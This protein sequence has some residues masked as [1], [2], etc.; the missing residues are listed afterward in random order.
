MN[1]IIERVKTNF[2]KN[3]IIIFV[4]FLVWVVALA[5]TVYAYRDSLGKESVGNLEYNYVEVLSS[6]K[7][8]KQIVDTVD[9]VNSV[10][11]RF[12]VYKKKSSNVTIEVIGQDSKKVYGSKTLKVRDVLGA[13]YN[14]VGLTENLDKKTD[15]KI[16][17]SVKTDDNNNAVG[18]WCSFNNV[19][20]GNPLSIGNQLRD[21]STSLR[22]LFDS[23]MFRIL[24]NSIVITSAV[25]VTLVIILALLIEPKK[26]N[27]YTL[28]VLIFGL[29]FMVVVVPL[30]AP[31]EEY[32]YRASLNVSNKLMNK[33]NPEMIEDE[34][35][36]YYDTFECNFNIGAVY[37][38]VIEHF[39]DEMEDLTNQPMY[40]LERGYVYYYDY[41]YYPQAIFITFARLLNLNLIKTYYF[42]RIGSLLFY[43]AMVYITLRKAPVFKDLIGIVALLPINIQQAACYSMDMW[44]SV[45]SLVI[46]A[47][48]LQWTYQDRKVSKADFIFLFV[49]EALLA[50][51]KMIYSLFVL[52]FWLVPKD[53]FYSNKHRIIALL[54]LMIPMGHQVGRQVVLR[55]WYTILSFSK[56]HAEDTGTS[57]VHEVYQVFSI[58]Y[59]LGHPLE[60]VMIVFRT[61]KHELKAWFAG[62]IGRYLSGLT[63]IIP[64]QLSHCIVGILV[65][66]AL[67][68]ENINLPVSVRLAGIGV[69]VLI[70]MLTLAVMLTGWTDVNDE[71]I[72]GIQGRYFTP[73]MPYVFFA[74]N[75]K[76]IYI[77]KKYS[78][79][80]IC[81]ESLLMFEIIVYMLSATLIY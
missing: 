30:S 66:S 46:F 40:N 69:C 72:Q 28:M 4:S 12:E 64:S 42:G 62:A 48:F 36:G 52:M 76:K 41:C 5:A 77:P 78:N 43:V 6:D 59:I 26:E 54:I 34:Y 16:I 39:N 18:V 27:I 7:D 22:L 14:T 67:V 29:I 2:K 24:T 9:G 31:D 63:L 38:T 10:A 13:A 44:I 8:L 70:G 79:I 74:L 53:K 56:V 32:H 68:F 60:A 23:E 49:I 1:S 11:V 21:G 80:I 45:L 19:F 58:K 25:F 33:E 73:L 61:I 15:K 55:I 47:C 71:Y 50:P 51:A 57:T 20:D 17:I 75:N 65:A 35:I 3:R 81:A 37:R